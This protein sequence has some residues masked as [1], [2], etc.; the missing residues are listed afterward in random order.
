MGQET[1][2][3]PPNSTLHYG[4]PAAGRAR[5]AANDG[6]YS[7]AASVRHY[8]TAEQPQCRALSSLTAYQ[9]AAALKSADESLDRLIRRLLLPRYRFVA[10]DGFLVLLLL[11]WILDKLHLSASKGL[12]RKSIGDEYE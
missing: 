9:S 4:G 8:T 3:S 11:H 12:M 2:T 7:L 6:I 10:L 5:W 1:N